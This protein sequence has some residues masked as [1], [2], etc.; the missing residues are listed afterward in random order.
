MAMHRVDRPR[1]AGIDREPRWHEC[2]PGNR[3]R[4]G[5]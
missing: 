4:Y 2:P 1:S 3:R 5:K